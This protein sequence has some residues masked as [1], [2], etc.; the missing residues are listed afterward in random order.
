[1]GLI[2]ERGK[3]STDSIAMLTKVR[4]LG[5]LELVVETLRLTVGALVNA[6]YKWSEKVLPASWEDKYG[7]RFV[8]QRWAQRK[9]PYTQ[10]AR[11]GKIGH[12][13]ST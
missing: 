11:G 1:M 12:Q 8:V 13:T 3:Q 10:Y 5:C 2:K 9:E 4:N 6:N 7:E